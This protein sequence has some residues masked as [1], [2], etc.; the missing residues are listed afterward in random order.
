PRRRGQ[1]ANFCK[2]VE[3]CGRRLVAFRAGAAGRTFPSS[4]A[5]SCL[6]IPERSGF[7]M[8][9][10]A[11]AIAAHGADDSAA[12]AA[13]ARPESADRAALR[14]VSRRG[15]SLLAELAKDPA[16]G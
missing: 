3:T 1:A 8:G 4:P 16:N 11:D 10:G 6:Q 13:M 7:G 14:A 12:P 15:V 5:R 9:D 2:L